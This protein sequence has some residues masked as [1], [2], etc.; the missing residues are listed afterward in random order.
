M[1]VYILF[2]KHIAFWESDRPLDES[3]VP[4]EDVTRQTDRV[5]R[6]VEHCFHNWRVFIRNLFRA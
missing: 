1:A 4:V 6:R 5:K 3:H 2:N